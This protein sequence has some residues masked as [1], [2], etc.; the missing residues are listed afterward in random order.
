MSQKCKKCVFMKR[1]ADINPCNTCV[2]NPFFHGREDNFKEAEITNVT[3]FEKIKAMTVKEMANVIVGLR[4]IDKYCKN[5][6]S[7]QYGGNCSCNGS[8]ELSCCIDWLN[9]IETEDQANE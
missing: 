2:E 7:E 5:K 8:D 4:F 9:E 6:Y 1:N 3:R